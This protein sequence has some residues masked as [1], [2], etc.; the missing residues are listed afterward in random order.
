M[1]TSGAF[2]AHFLLLMKGLTPEST[3]WFII[4]CFWLETRR[5]L[6]KAPS[7]LS[8]ATRIDFKY[9]Y[10]INKIVMCGLK[11]IE[12]HWCHHI[13]KHNVLFLLHYIHQAL[14]WFEWQHAATH[15]AALSRGVCFNFPSLLQQ[16]PWDESLAGSDSWG[17]RGPQCASPP[18]PSTHTSPTLCFLLPLHRSVCPAST[19]PYG[20]WKTWAP[21]CFQ[22]D[23][24]HLFNVAWG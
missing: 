8:D 15:V 20:G 2:W 17:H 5:K 1:E 6:I 14:W 16:P 24:Q 3:V 9:Q 4:I 23:S 19:T 21:T 10:C 18:S 13:N 22:S 7:N 11:K 12:Y